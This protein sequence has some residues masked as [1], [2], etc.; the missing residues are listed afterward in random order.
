M[1]EKP[2]IFKDLKVVVIE[3]VLPGVGGLSQMEHILERII[4]IGLLP[5]KVI[6]LVVLTMDLG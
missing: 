5:V 2:L 3:E 4:T 6:L 1:V